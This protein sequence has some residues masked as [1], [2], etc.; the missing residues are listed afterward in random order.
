MFL[1]CF[2]LFV[3]LAGSLPWVAIAR[4]SHKPAW[5]LAVYLIASVNVT[6]S[7]YIAG[8]LRSLDQP[9][10]MMTF[11]ALF[12]AVGWLVW[13]RND[14]P[15]VWG[16][17]EG[18]RP[19]FEVR[20]LRRE[21]LLAL[22]VVFTMLA[23]AFALV[24]LIYIPQNNIDSLSTHLSRIVFW[25]QN[26]TFLPWETLRMDQVWYPVNAQLQTYWTLLFLG[27]DRLVGSAQWLAAL[28]SAAGVFGLARLFGYGRR[29]SA[30]ASLLFLSFPLIALQATT[31]Q[32]DLMTTVF[33]LLSVYFFVLGLQ[34]KSFS[35]LSFSALSVGIG[36][37]V[38][39]S[40]FLLLPVLGALVVLAFLQWGRRCLKPLVFWAFNVLAAVALLG[41]YMYAVNWVYFGGLFGSPDY[42]ERMIET[43]QSV[44]DSGMTTPQTSHFAHRAALVV[45][46]YPQPLALGEAGRDKNWMLPLRTA[47]FTA[48][49]SPVSAGEG[50]E[51]LAGQ[52]LLPMPDS[53]LWHEIWLELLYNAP[54]LLYQSLDT[55]GLPRPLD[56]YAHKVKAR[57]AAAFFRAIGFEEIE[58]TAYA[59]PGHTFRFANKNINEESFAWYGPLSFLLIFPALLLEGRRALRQRFFLLLGPGI[60]LMIFLPLEILLRPGWDPFQGRYFAPLVAFCTPL[61]AI[62]FKRDGSAFYEWLIGALAVMI[63]TVTLLYNPAKP[64]LGK[65]ADDFHV[66]NNDDRIFL[67]TIQRKN[68]R[69]MYYLVEKFVPPDATL[70]YYAPFFIM[71]YPLFGENLRRRLVSVIS[72][73]QVVDLAWLKEQGVEYLLIPAQEGYPLPA[74]EYELVRQRGGWNLYKLQSLP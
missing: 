21:P 37:G 35:A 23:Y 73:E 57:L 69:E 4:L 13:L 60:A 18:W 27:N 48:L 51:G 52:Q 5:L 15:S 59:A 17:F 33:F 2:A 49:F 9:G 72:P 45:S 67:Q 50:Q 30:F 34:T 36:V 10:V 44:P 38:K 16:P 58:G 65:L 68:D 1:F 22:Q 62:W 66:W 55:S 41:A 74:A 64:T 6:L 26:G 43:P 42:L 53:P 47:S 28:I 56:G 61:T 29:Q 14:R 40:F 25:R 11:H 8:S 7:S 39:K 71:D 12:G 32:T 19:R 54:R 31:T 24:Q 3:L 46:S 63:L 70:A 20:S